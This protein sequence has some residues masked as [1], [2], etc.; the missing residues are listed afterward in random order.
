MGFRMYQA[1][2]PCAEG[3]F[4]NRANQMEQQSFGWKGFARPHP[5][6]SPWARVFAFGIIRL[7]Y[8]HPPIQPRVY[9]EALGAFHL[10]LGGEG[11]DEGGLNT[12][13]PAYLQVATVF[14]KAP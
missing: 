5:A 2:S 13:I 4:E 6:L 11:R 8:A 14:S 3:A 10:L 12:I 7:F 1:P 9:P